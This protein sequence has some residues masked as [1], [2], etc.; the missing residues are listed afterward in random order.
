MII[1]IKKHGK[2][3]D[4]HQ[5]N[6]SE[7]KSLKGFYSEWHK[8]CMYKKGYKYVLKKY[9]FQKVYCNRLKVFVYQRK[10]A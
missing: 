5:L 7:Y 10:L 4:I 9:Q 6:K 2:I 3:L 1:R 8:A